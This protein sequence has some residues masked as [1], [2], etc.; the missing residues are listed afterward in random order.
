MTGWERNV[1]TYE[2]DRTVSNCPYCGY[3]DVEVQEHRN[4]NRKSLSFFCPKCGKG[5]H[6][7]GFAE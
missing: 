2:T 3:E 6:F 5:D 1:V 4:G 7:D